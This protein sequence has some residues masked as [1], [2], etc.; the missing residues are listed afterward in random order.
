MLGA[1]AVAS[2]RLIEHEVL[3]EEC[4]GRAEPLG[5][6]RIVGQGHHRAPRRDRAGHLAAVELELAGRIQCGRPIQPRGEI[7]R[8]EAY[9][10]LGRLDGLVRP[11]RCFR[12]VILTAGEGGEQARHVG[13]VVQRTHVVRAFGEDLLGQRVGLLRQHL[14]FGQATEGCEDR[15]LAVGGLGP[16]CGGS[17]ILEI[18]RAEAFQNF[19]RFVAGGQTLSGQVGRG[20][21]D[22]TH[23]VHVVAIQLQNSM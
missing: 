18:Q 11:F 12:I 9:L 17:E 23:P 20:G 2:H 22:G 8:V 16:G 19:E 7:G 21:L 15:G 4:V 3:P 13:A 14:R 10:F 1:G 5:C 6:A